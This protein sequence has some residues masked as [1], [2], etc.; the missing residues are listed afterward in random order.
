MFNRVS[1]LAVQV[2]QVVC[3]KN[4]LWNMML[5]YKVNL[6]KFKRC[7]EKSFASVNKI[8]YWFD[9]GFLLESKY[10]KYTSSLCMFS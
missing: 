7:N 5:L 4:C 1:C 8:D 10:L 3:D 2:R 9:L 6:S